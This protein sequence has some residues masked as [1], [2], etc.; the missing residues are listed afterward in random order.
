MKRAFLAYDDDCIKVDNSKINHHNKTCLLI[1]TNDCPT[2]RRHRASCWA[3]IMSS[4]SQLP[5]ARQDV[6]I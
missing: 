1:E 2:F 4:S 6:N 3:A 5:E